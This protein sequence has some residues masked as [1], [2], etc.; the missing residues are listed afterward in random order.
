[1]SACP[2]PTCTL[3]TVPRSHQWTGK[4]APEGVQAN[5]FRLAPEV[6]LACVPSCYDHRKICDLTRRD[7]STG[8]GECLELECQEDIIVV[9]GLPLWRYS[10]QSNCE[11]ILDLNGVYERE[12]TDLSMGEGF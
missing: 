5:P 4:L 8:L 3:Q 6:I 1:M 11:E 12:P 10:I 9:S 7:P 2:S